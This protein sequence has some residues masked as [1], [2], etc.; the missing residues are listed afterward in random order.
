MNRYGHADEVLRDLKTSLAA[1]LTLGEVSSQ[2]SVMANSACKS[3]HP[4]DCPIVRIRAREIRTR[5]SIGEVI[6]TLGTFGRANGIS[7]EIVTEAIHCDYEERPTCGD[8][9][10]GNSSFSHEIMRDD[11]FER[12]AERLNPDR[13]HTISRYRPGILADDRGTTIDISPVPVSSSPRS[14]GHALPIAE[15]E[16]THGRV[17]FP[18]QT[19]S[20][21]DLWPYIAPFIGYFLFVELPAV[22]FTGK[23]A[24]QHLM[25]FLAVVLHAIQG[26]FE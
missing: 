15:W 13:S 1:Q 4:N 25:Q 18:P 21:L 22:T 12:L 23:W 3:N 24:F 5:A 7:V 26:A 17:N 6:S 8:N 16:A 19:V 10:E 2:D 20:R 9:Y 11:Y 14:V